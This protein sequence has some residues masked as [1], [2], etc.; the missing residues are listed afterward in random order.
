MVLILT[1]KMKIGG[2]MAKCSNYYSC[3]RELLIC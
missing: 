2:V 3:N 1:L